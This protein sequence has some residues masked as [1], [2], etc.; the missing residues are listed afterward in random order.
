MCLRRLSSIAYDFRY[1]DAICSYYFVDG[2]PST[3]TLLVMSDTSCKMVCMTGLLVTTISALNLFHARQR[4]WFS[5]TFPARKGWSRTNFPTPAGYLWVCLRVF[6]LFT[7][8]QKGV[9]APHI[10]ELVPTPKLSGF[11]E[12]QAALDHLLRLTPTTNNESYQRIQTSTLRTMG[13]CS[14]HSRDCLFTKQI[15]RSDVY[16][17]ET[18]AFGRES[19]DMG[20]VE[21]RWWNFDTW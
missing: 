11:P 5:S 6:T 12:S 7:P 1:L 4:S 16:I 10:Y 3:R 17:I 20:R 9:N 2:R 19:E 8:L 14:D 18:S 21:L 13:W 15:V